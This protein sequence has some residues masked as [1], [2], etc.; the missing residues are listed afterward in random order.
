MGDW[1]GVRPKTNAP[2][3]L[4]DLK[5]DIGEKSDIAKAHPAELKRIEAIMKQAHTDN[6]EWPKPKG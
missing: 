5:S 1:K 2:V 6:P 4:Y 3:E